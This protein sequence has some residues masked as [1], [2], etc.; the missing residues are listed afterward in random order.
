MCVNLDM[1]EAKFVNFSYKSSVLKFNHFLKSIGHSAIFLGRVYMK[2]MLND[3]Y[4]KKN[5]IQSLL[6]GFS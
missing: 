6:F 4:Y 3:A 2:Y 5:N 1:S